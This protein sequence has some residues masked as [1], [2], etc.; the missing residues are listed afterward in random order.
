M[1]TLHIASSRNF[2]GPTHHFLSLHT[3]KC[4]ENEGLKGWSPCKWASAVFIQT[5]ER[6]LL[7]Q[8]RAA[9]VM[10]IHIQYS[11][12]TE[13]L[14]LQKKGSLSETTFNTESHGKISSWLCVGSYPGILWSDSMWN[15]CICLMKCYDALKCCA[16]W[17]FQTIQTTLLG[18]HWQPT[19]DFNYQINITKVFRQHQA[20]WQKLWKKPKNSFGTHACNYLLGKIINLKS[21]PG[22]QSGLKIRL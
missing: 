15:P 16:F 9:L 8:R 18:L 2:V 20:L 14:P 17:E 5:H 21:P 10:I 7:A 4:K 19:P 3:K 11:F 13:T 6:L 22:W 1:F 12:I